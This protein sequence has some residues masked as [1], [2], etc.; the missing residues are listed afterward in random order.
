MSRIV[1]VGED[2]LWFMLLETFR[3]NFPNTNDGAQ[4]CLE[5]YRSYGRWLTRHQRRQLGTES[6]DAAGTLKIM[7]A[8]KD[9][10]LHGEALQRAYSAWRTLADEITLESF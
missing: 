6:A 4:R 3:R 9:G 8:G 2:D 1:A 5:L 7:L 10:S